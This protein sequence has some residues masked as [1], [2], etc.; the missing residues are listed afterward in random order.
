MP[1]SL[2]LTTP[3]A[4]ESWP[5][6]VPTRWA[7][8]SLAQY[9]ALYTQPDAS[10]VEVLCGLPAGTLE[11]LSV[12]AVGHLATLLDFATDPNP[13]LELLPTP[14]LPDIGSLSYGTLLLAQQYLAANPDKPALFYMPR[15]LA[16]YRQ[17]MLWGH[18]DNADRLAACEAALLAGP[19]TEAYPDAAFFLASLRRLQSGMPP[20][21]TTSPRPKTRSSKP[22]AKSSVNGSGRFSAWMRR[23]AAPS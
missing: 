3:D 13:V 7:D 9:V 23:L 16:L 10:P 14:G 19:V 11:R 22:G 18:A 8:V 17:T 2:T 21:P 12:Q 20:T 15:L 4:S 1:T 6:T 5:V